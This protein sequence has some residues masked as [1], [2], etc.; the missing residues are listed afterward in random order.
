M[1]LG[2]LFYAQL[3]SLE[4]PTAIANDRAK[5]GHSQ[6]NILENLTQSLSVHALDRKNW[7][8]VEKE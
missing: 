3:L 2:F 6:L 5:G 1:W 7:K 4:Q 8:V